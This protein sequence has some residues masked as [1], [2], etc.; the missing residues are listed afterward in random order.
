MLRGLFIRGFSI[1]FVPFVVSFFFYSDD[2]ELTTSYAIFKSVM[3]VT[4]TLSVLIAAT[5]RL[6]AIPSPTV[7]AVVFLMIS[8]LLDVLVVI[9]FVGLRLDD[10]VEQVGLIYLIIPAITWVLL[11]RHP[12]PPM[13]VAS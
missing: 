2:G 12:H 1:W 3:V 4:L 9:P 8:V 11:S 7:A 5:F 10:Y 6:K 13:T